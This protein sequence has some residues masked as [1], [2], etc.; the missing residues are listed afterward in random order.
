MNRVEVGMAVQG[1]SN[2]AVAAGTP[3]ASVDLA[4]GWVNLSKPLTAGVTAA[5]AMRSGITPRAYPTPITFSR[6]Y[7]DAEA[8]ALERDRL[9][10]QAAV[11]AA[12][13]F[14]GS[15]GASVLIP[16]GRYRFDG[17]VILPTFVNYTDGRQ[18][19]SIL[20]TP[21]SFAGTR[22]TPTKD[23]G[24][25]SAVFSC[26]DPGAH[27][28]NGRDLYRP[29]GLFC[30]GDFGGLDIAQTLLPVVLNHGNRPTWGGTPVA[31]D[32]LKLG[33]R[34]TMRTDTV[35][36]S[37]FDKGIRAVMDH[38]HWIH[39]HLRNNFVGLYMDD[40][41]P[42]IHSDN[43]WEQPYFD[44]NMWAGVS[45]SPKAFLNVTAIKPY[46]SSNP[47]AIECEPGPNPLGCIQRTTIVEPNF[48]NPACGIIKDNG[49]RD[50]FAA[51]GGSRTI[52]DLDYV[53]GFTGGYGAFGP[54]AVPMPRGG[55][56]W[57]AYFDVLAANGFNITRQQRAGAFEL[58]PRTMDAS[59]LRVS[60]LDA[61]AGFGQGGFRLEGSGVLRLIQ[62]AAAVSRNLVTG[63]GGI[64]GDFW[65]SGSN[66]NIV[67]QGPGF[68]AR[69]MPFQTGPTLPLGTAVEYGAVPGP[70]GAVVQ[71]AGQGTSR[72]VAGV[73]CQ[74]FRTTNPTQSGLV[75]IICYGG[76]R[77]PVATTTSQGVGTILKSGSGRHA[78]QAVAAT[79][80]NEG[81]TLGIVQGTDSASLAYIK[82]LWPGQD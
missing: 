23:F 80:M 19:V 36:V 34:R 17:P 47:Y 29:E 12:R 22:I 58:I 33:P 77:L 68:K 63:P 51:T 25:G 39:P 4:N 61:Y 79:G 49:I 52:S 46:I 76:S 32:G 43:L 30:T 57:A 42:N 55:C 56:R 74:D 65:A 50:G 69:P 20:G 28:T 64:T 45:I 78:G 9:G 14:T 8:R 26:G 13:A 38:T 81:Q 53:G 16:T 66:Q 70:G 82:P 27:A 18:S 35:Y 21:G 60:R 5:T 7:T 48:E 10:V 40:L 67:L 62:A 44:G 31:M 15:L 41:Q 2:G 37:H 3:V 54:G 1:P 72:P 73:A 75:P 11:E 71:P 24:P 6:R 59:L